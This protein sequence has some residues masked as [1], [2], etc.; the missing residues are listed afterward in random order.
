MNGWLSVCQRWLALAC[1]A[2]VP[3]CSSYEAQGQFWP[4]NGGP[5]T[6]DEGALTAQGGSSGTGA[7]P[8]GGSGN[9]QSGTGN[10]SGGS[11]AMA[12]AGSDSIAGSD[13]TAGS[14][15]FGGSGSVGGSSAVGG[16]GSIGGSSSIGGSGAMGGSGSVGGSSSGGATS[17]SCSLRV[18]VTTTAPG[19]NYAPRN[20]GAIWVSDSSGRFVK[21][22]EV[23]AAKRISRVV[24]WNNA[25][26]NAGV[27]ANKVDAVTSATLSAHRTHN[28]SWNCRDYNGQSVPDGTYRVYF[29]VADSN[30]A[31]PSTFQT[32]EK[33]S[34]P[35]TASAS[36]GN[37]QGIQ[38]A[39]TP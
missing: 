35:A 7:N 36:M 32:F 23:W 18:T 20:V 3:C 17:G 13:S 15:A 33:G 6:V 31:G 21:S 8:P 38:L 16:S 2:A 37:F 12:T 24:A 4:T 30:N 34:A 11:G 25:T 10:P 29:E 1:L 5:L 22:L 19:G 26:R 28:V 39:F 27:P 14:P 9:A